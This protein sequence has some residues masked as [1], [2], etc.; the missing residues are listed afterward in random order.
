MLEHSRAKA[1][2][3]WRRWTFRTWVGITI[4]FAAYVAILL[5]FVGH[6]R[7]GQFL[8]GVPVPFVMILLLLIGLGW[9]VWFVTARL[10]PPGSIRR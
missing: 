10:R 2:G 4:V 3:Q 5:A 8:L 7:I 6:E 9:L 1:G